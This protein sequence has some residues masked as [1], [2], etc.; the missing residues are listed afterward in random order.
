MSQ[1]R[2]PVPTDLTQPSGSPPAVPGLVEVGSPAQPA[3]SQDVLPGQSPAEGHGTRPFRPIATWVLIAI[4]VFLWLAMLPFGGSSDPNVL[5]RFGIKVNSLIVQGQYWRFVTPIFLHIGILHLAFNTYA[6]YVIG[7]QIEHF[8]GSARFLVIYL[9]SGISG[10][11]LSFV[12]SPRASAGASGAIFGLI[13]TEVVF[14]Y[15]YRNA[16]GRRGRQQLYNLLIVVGYNIVFTFAVP[17]IDVWGHVGGLLAGSI[18][19]WRLIPRYAVAMSKGG[20]IVVD[21]NQPT[22]W[23]PVALGALFLLVLGAGL[24]IAWQARG[25]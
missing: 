12:F 2:P 17:N 5:I 13:G 6:L 16:F 1:D 25:T 18:L 3:A 9:L 19:G 21:Q 24:A 7:P 20:P 10:V 15:H 23:G 22:R 14:F 11:L 4:N 8:F